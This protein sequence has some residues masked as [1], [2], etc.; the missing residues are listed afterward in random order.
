MTF[1]IGTILTSALLL[2]L[3]TC[4]QPS[5]DVAMHTFDKFEYQFHDASVPPD[6]HRSYVITVTETTISK[7]VN[8]Y[9]DTISLDE[10]PISKANFELLQ[11]TVVDA[12]IKNCK[13]PEDDGC[14]GGTGISMRWF[15]A[16]VKAFGGSRWKCGGQETG[17]MCGDTGKVLSLLD[18]WLK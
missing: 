15:K 11:Q 10:K 3:Q 7:W 14:T 2:L 17:D 18:S 1:S 8:S 5:N 12:K 16:N 4:Q 13:L 9:G 6:Y